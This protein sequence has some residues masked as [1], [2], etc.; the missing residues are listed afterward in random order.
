MSTETKQLIE[1]LRDQTHRF[2]RR[3][4]TT[5]RAGVRDYDWGG[6]AELLIDIFR[7]FKIGEED[8]EA[9]MNACR[10]YDKGGPYARKEVSE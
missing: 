1:R 10:E 6:E 7:M 5:L 4:E 8:Y 9:V 2:P 3:D